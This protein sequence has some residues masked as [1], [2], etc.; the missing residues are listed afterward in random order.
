MNL[1]TKLEFYKVLVLSFQLTYCR[2]TQASFDKCMK[3]NLDM[4]RPH[5]GYHSLLKVHQ[6]DR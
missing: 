4:E 1:S 5:Y 2:K 3:D 6:T